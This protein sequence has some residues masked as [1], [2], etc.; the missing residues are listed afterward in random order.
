MNESFKQ[1]D[2]F[3]ID[4]NFRSPISTHFFNSRVMALNGSFRQSLDP[5][6][7]KAEYEYSLYAVLTSF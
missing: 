4:Y 6:I 5:Y 1:F 3:T 2:V 7:G